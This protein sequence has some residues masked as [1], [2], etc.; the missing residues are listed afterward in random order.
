[1][2]ASDITFC[3][4]IAIWLGTTFWINYI[5]CDACCRRRIKG[6]P[7]CADCDP[8]KTAERR[9]GTKPGSWPGD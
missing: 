6:R 7:C 9:H 3:V 2:S 4:V 8:T 1:M 5:K